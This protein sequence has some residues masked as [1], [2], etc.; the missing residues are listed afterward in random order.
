MMS[1]FVCVLTWVEC[2]AVVH[3]TI[4]SLSL[5]RPFEAEQFIDSSMF[6]FQNYAIMLA[7]QIGKKSAHQNL[8]LNLSGKQLEN[9]G[10]EQV[11]QLFELFEETQKSVD[12]DN[13]V[14][15]NPYVDAKKDS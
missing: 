5:Y 4:L 12:P 3:V 15:A 9:L 8:G 2:I 7:K 13:S 14:G 1:L 11:G 10:D 6:L